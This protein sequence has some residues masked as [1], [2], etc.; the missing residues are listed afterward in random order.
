MKSFLFSALLVVS[1]QAMAGLNCQSDLDAFKNTMGSCNFGDQAACDSVCIALA[2][3][4]ISQAGCSQSD[5]ELARSKGRNEVINDLRA[6]ATRQDMA[7]GLDDADCTARVRQKVDVLRQSA[8]NECNNKASSIKNCQVMG[9]A[10][11]TVAS[12]SIA[13]IKGVGDIE[14]KAKSSDEASC[15]ANALQRAKDDALISCKNMTGYDCTLNA[16]STAIVTHKISKALLGIGSDK[17][18]CRA[19]ITALPSQNVRVQ[20]TAEIKAVNTAVGL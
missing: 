1:A 5:L 7:Y 15:R 16:D 20:C 18:K 10:R 2:P 3:K 14:L 8:I 13:N 12:A 4:S 6:S 9:E 17:R 11:I 19:E